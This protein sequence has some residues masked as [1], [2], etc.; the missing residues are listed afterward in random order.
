MLGVWTTICRIHTP[1]MS[2]VARPE[3]LEPTTNHL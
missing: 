2:L 1:I 3:G